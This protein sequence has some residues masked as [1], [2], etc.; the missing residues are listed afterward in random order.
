MTLLIPFTA[1]E[2]LAV[3]KNGSELIVQVGHHRRNILLPR[4]VAALE[5]KEAKKE[6]E[7]L[8]LVFH[9]P[10]AVPQAAGVKGGKP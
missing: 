1:L 6:G 4:S 10:G 3:V 8:R 5:V 7:T 2:E 9:D